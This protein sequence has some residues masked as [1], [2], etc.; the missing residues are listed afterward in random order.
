MEVANAKGSARLLHLSLA[1]SRLLVGERFEPAWLTEQLHA[2]GRTPV[3]LYPDTPDCQAPGLPACPAP[4]ATTLVVLDGTWRKSRK[5]LHLNPALQRLPRIALRDTAPSL[6]RIRKAQG[7]DQLST[8]EAACHALAQIDG[9]AGR[10]QALLARFAA[11]NDAFALHQGHMN[12][13]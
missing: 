6:Y 8:L 3:L 1:G 4:G 7:P 11:F 2:G 12:R 13:A 10:Y 5:M 9:D